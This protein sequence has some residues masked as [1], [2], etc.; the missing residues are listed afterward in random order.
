MRAFRY[1]RLS[2]SERAYFCFIS[3]RSYHS[4]ECLV[5]RA[6]TERLEDLASKHVEG[7]V[8]LTHPHM[9]ALVLL[10]AS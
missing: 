4:E 10:L 8:L 6:S 3:I 1:F 9:V 7:K 5:V 2:K